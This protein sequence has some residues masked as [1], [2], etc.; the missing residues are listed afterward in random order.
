[1]KSY[2]TVGRGIE[3]YVQFKCG[4]EILLASQGANRNQK[5]I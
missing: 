4:I 5:N 3:S 1:M 2:S